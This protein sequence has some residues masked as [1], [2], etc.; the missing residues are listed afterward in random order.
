MKHAEQRNA[1]RAFDALVNSGVSREQARDILERITRATQN[2]SSPL[3]ESRKMRN[4][5]NGA[6]GGFYA[7]IS[8][9]IVSRNMV[10]RDAIDLK[11][12]VA[13]G[14]KPRIIKAARYATASLAA[15]A[16]GGIAI[17]TAVGMMTAALTGAGGDDE[18]K[19]REREWIR[20]ATD[21]LST[22]LPQF[23]PIIDMVSGSLQ[24]YQYGGALLTD[25]PSADALNAIG[26]VVRDLRNGK[27]IKSETAWK[28]ARAAL[29]L[30]GAPMSGPW[31]AT[32]AVR[33]ATGADESDTPQ[34]RR[35]PRQRQRQRERAIDFS[36]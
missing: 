35:P 29:T 13:A 3:E 18:D 12:A 9:V 17:P 36:E 34:R 8:Q 28:I 11:R 5:R 2:S 30:L 32:R 24:G 4:V 27:E 7:F 16:M 6:L 25:R 10:V 19:K 1:I 22:I 31:F 15:L 21:L 33:H 20:V 23:R 26:Q 14:D